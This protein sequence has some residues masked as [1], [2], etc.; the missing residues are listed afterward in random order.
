MPD[1]IGPIAYALIG[2]VVGSFLNVVADRAPQGQSLLQPSSHCPGCQ[3]RLAPQELIPVFS[4]LALRGRCRVCGARIPL[5]V[6]VVELAT[7]L[8]FALLWWVFGPSL[9]LALNTVYVCV[10]VVVFAV[11]LE[12]KLVLNVVILPAIAFALLALPAQFVRPVTAYS[13]APALLLRHL[14]LSQPV[15]GMI[16]QAAGGL[17]AFGIFWLVWFIS[18]SGM[19][20]GDVRLAAF[21]GLITGFP[22]ALAAVFGS[23]VLGG[24]VAIALLVMRKAGMKTAIPFGP[25]LVVT[26]LIMVVFGD[27]LIA[28]YLAR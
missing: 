10:L 7:G 16:S 22:G 9:R 19:G 3:K 1:L 27:P 2:M 15:L 8:L 24:V 5:R 11:D 20:Y 25:F 28:W 13:A 6:L 12:H 17:V 4:Y 14:R 23:F 26:T 18:P 21:A